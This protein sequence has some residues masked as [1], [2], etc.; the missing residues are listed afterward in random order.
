MYMYMQ[1]LQ[2]SLGRV[3]SLPLITWRLG[4]WKDSEARATEVQEECL[5][6]L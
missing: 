6:N 2:V 3:D 1:P 5:G 4:Q